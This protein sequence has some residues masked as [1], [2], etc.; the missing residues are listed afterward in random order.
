M[1]ADEI[2]FGNPI[3]GELAPYGAPQNPPN[4]RVTRPYAD[5]SMP[6]YGPHDGLDIGNGQTGADIVAMARGR[7][8][9]AFFD[10]ASGGAG[11]VRIDHGDGWTTGYAHM[12]K[13]F[14][15]AGQDVDEGEL[16]ARLDNTGWSSGAHLHFDTTKG[17]SRKDPWP[18][19]RQN[20]EGEEDDMAT[21]IQEDKWVDRVNNRVWHAGPNGAKFRAGPGPNQDVIET[22]KAG[23]E[24][25]PHA[26]A[27]G[28]SVTIGGESSNRWFFGWRNQHDEYIVGAVSVLELVDQEPVETPEP[29]PAPPCPDPCDQVASQAASTN[30]LA[31]LV[32]LAALLIVFL[33]AALVVFVATA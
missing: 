2:A 18:L 7:V 28:G 33:L 19:L 3:R 24:F 29:E 9:Q 4:F 17:S 8:Y 15:K 5:E 31:L 32:L 6:Q 12:D 13:L 22:I 26:K 16:V 11:I 27:I 23:G 1:A 25:W 10:Q 20:Q 30:R 21:T 14:V